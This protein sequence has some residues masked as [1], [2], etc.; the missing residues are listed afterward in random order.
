MTAA[1]IAVAGVV[2]VLTGQFTLYG[3]GR[4]WS[5]RYVVDVMA[6]V[7]L[8]MQYA[9]VADPCTLTSL[10]VSGFLANPAWKPNTRHSRHGQ[11]KA[12][13]DWATAAGLVDPNPMLLVPKPKQVIGVPKPV[14]RDHFLRLL[15]TDMH[16]RTR[17]MVYL[18]ALQGLRAH[19]IAH[20]RGQDIDR[21]AGTL[22]VRGKG[23]REDVMPL[24]RIIAD[25][26]ET[27]PRR[28]WWFPANATRPGEHVRAKSVSQIVG[29]AMRRADI[30]GTA[31]C[32]RHWYATELLNTGTDLR[33]V[34]TLMRHSNIQTT[35][36]YTYVGGARQAEA[37]DRLALPSLPG[38]A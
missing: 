10:Q 29:L 8:A 32:L 38:C 4:G 19:E 30:P 22:T 5:E 11:L 1:A 36:I 33:T 7:R 15:N 24:H 12:F 26:A 20:T 27:M 17:V 2:S 37:V 9:E 35:Q 25:V 13:F 16:H 34:Q 3:R 18:A 28:G 21:V 31:H 6:A 14:H 23:G